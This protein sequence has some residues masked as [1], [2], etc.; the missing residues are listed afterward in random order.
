MRLTW[1]QQLIDSFPCVLTV[2]KIVIKC[3]LYKIILQYFVSISRYIKTW[4]GATNKR[5]KFIL[6]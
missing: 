5:P 3:Q 1:N 6:Y 4:E 2:Y